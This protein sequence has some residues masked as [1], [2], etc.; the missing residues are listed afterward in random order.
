MDRVGVI[1]LGFLYKKISIYLASVRLRWATSSYR[2]DA[3]TLSC[4]VFDRI[5]CVSV[6]L[7]GSRGMKTKRKFYQTVLF[8]NVAIN[9]AILA[10]FA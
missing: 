7:G 1:P 10:A 6:L 3:N 8:Q 5:I 9:V 4:K 2:I